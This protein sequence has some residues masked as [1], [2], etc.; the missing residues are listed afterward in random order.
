MGNLLVYSPSN[1]LLFEVIPELNSLTKCKIHLGTSDDIMLLQQKV[2]K[3]S[4]SEGFFIPS[5]SVRIIFKDSLLEGHEAVIDS[6]F[7]HR[8]Y[9]KVNIMEVFASLVT[10]SASTVEG[11]VKMALDI[12]DFDGNSVISQDEM[13]IMCVAFM[14]GISI[15]T[16][17]TV[18][19]PIH[20]KALANEAFT[21]A[22]SV[23]DGKITFEELMQWIAGNQVLFNLLTKV[24]PYSDKNDRKSI[25]KSNNLQIVKKRRVSSFVGNEKIRPNTAVTKK[26]YRGNSTFI[27]DD[28][29]KLV[30]K[31]FKK[32]SNK[33]GRM[34]A[35]DFFMILSRIPMLKEAYDSY[36][37]YFKYRMNNEISLDEALNAIHR[38]GTLRF[39]KA[40][41]PVKTFD[42][43]DLSPQKL[44]VLQRLFVK[45]DTNH[46]GYISYD[47][48]KN[49]LSNHFSLAALEDMFIEYDINKNGLL[50]MREFLQLFAPL[51]TKLPVK[52]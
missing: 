44:M 34:L 32:G 43:K 29:D 17:A 41:T 49:A 26:N 9:K 8:K 36:F 1:E 21:L 33:Y 19:D 35:K 2:A 10:Y 39:N 23:P 37:H 48:L 11:K 6:Y 27:M 22:D 14:R 25:I 20:T 42:E 47:E 40:D 28:L 16:Q 38:K 24:P 51:N 7:E 4:V 30:K 45:Y 3:V 12:F 52:V 31:L 15:M 13:V 46:D 50:D 5:S 18:Y